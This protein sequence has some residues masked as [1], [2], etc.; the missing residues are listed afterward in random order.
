[1]Y[2]SLNVTD[3]LA[4]DLRMR[5]DSPDKAAELANMGKMQAAQAAKMFDK[6]DIS[7]DGADVHIQVGLSQQKLNDLIKQFGGMLGG[8]MGGGMAGGAPGATP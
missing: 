7:A 4:L 1:M 3:G 5:L 2:G 6:L 8:A